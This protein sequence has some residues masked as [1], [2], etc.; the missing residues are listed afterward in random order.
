[1]RKLIFQ[2]FIH[3]TGNLNTNVEV[4][5]ISWLENPQNKIACAETIYHLESTTIL[6]NISIWFESKV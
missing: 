6:Q 2:Y 1:M 5:L 3:W 4:A